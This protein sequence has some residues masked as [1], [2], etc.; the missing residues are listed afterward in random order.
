MTEIYY[1]QREGEGLDFHGEM[2]RAIAGVS[3]VA[4][5][6]LVVRGEGAVTSELTEIS[7]GTVADNYMESIIRG[8][9]GVIY[10]DN[11]RSLMNL[12]DRLDRMILD[13][14][15]SLSLIAV[16]RQLDTESGRDVIE[17]SEE[18]ADR[19]LERYEN[20]DKALWHGLLVAREAVFANEELSDEGK[21]GLVELWEDAFN[22]KDVGEIADIL[23]LIELSLSSRR[24]QLR[25]RKEEY[26]QKAIEKLRLESQ[27]MN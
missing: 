9:E 24:A 21:V 19:L 17:V 3:S 4:L 27:E 15:R 8:G 25:K 18:D 20:G 10:P 26:T 23:R 12:V 14:D 5:R 1:E 2:E 7:G 6:H 22:R 11:G 13:D 16:S